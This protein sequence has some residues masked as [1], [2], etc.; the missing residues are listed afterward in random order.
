[1]VAIQALEPQTCIYYNLSFI[2]LGLFHCTAGPASRLTLGSLPA[3][4]GVLATWSNFVNIPCLLSCR[5]EEQPGE[6]TWKI[7]YMIVATGRRSVKT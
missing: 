2:N 5:T 7:S 1:M 6:W 4:Y 3:E